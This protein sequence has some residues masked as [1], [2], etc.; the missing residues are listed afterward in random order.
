MHENEQVGSVDDSLFVWLNDSGGII[1]ELSMFPKT[2]DVML[3]ELFILPKMVTCFLKIN[4]NA[5]VN[6]KDVGARIS[7]AAVPV[8][9][10]HRRSKSK[11]VL[12]FA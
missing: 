1:V 6:S 12:D 10:F 3:L 5:Y 4:V 7:R 8:P 2:D 9:Y 11:N